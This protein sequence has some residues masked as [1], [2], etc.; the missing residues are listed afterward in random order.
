[1]SPNKQLIETL[2]KTAPADLATLLAED[3]EWIE[4]V[5]GVP[6]SGA[7]KQGK[8]A[9]I[10]NYGD[11]KPEGRIS[12]MIEENNVIVAEGTVRIPKKDG[13]SL[14]VQYC[15]IYEVENGKVKRKSSY[16]ALVKDTE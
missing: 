9:Y 3:V 4:W 16:G 5:D 11:D 14:T 8:A 6:A 10:E 1:M 15:D 13:S 2:A 12:R 7:R